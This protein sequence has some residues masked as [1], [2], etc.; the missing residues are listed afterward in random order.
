MNADTNP[1]TNTTIEWMPAWQPP[2]LDIQKRIQDLRSCL[3][4]NSPFYHK[5]HEANIKAAIKLYEDKKIDGTQEICL[6][7]GKIIP[8]EKNHET[9]W[10]WDEQPVCYQFAEKQ[11]Y[12]HRP[13]GPTAYE[14]MKK[15]YSKTF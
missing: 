14:V 6:Q 12:D 8:K 2:P 1:K 4:P 9:P 13:F 5:E 11:V 15:G 10:C 7:D 3:D